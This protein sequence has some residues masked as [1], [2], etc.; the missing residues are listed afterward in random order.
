MKKALAL[1]AV[2]MLAFA[3]TA[4]ASDSAKSKAG[5]KTANGTISKLDTASK[6]LTLTDAKGAS[7][8]VQWTDSTRILGGELKE[9]AAASLGYGESDGKMWASWIKVAEGSQ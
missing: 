9:G 7:W 6:S 8:T 4:A 3:L 2:G 5:E 1:A